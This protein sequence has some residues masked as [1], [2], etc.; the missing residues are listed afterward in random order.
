MCVCFWEKVWETQQVH[1]AE[2][3]SHNQ[4]F[5]LIIFGHLDNTNIFL[6]KFEEL[7]LPSV[8]LNGCVQFPWKSVWD[9]HTKSFSLLLV[10]YGEM[11]RRQQVARALSQSVR[12]L[13][14]RCR[15]WGHIVEHSCRAGCALH[16]WGLMCSAIKLPN[17]R[18]VEKGS[19]RKGRP[20]ENDGSENKQSKTKQKWLRQ[21]VR[22]GEQMKCSYNSFSDCISCIQ[23]TV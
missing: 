7:E 16:H 21:R 3:P 12:H 14:G 17:T 19:W 15:A 13:S 1:T 11:P 18:R 5:W 23:Q 2:K 6:N 9:G 20:L 10:S 22:K 8:G 4:S